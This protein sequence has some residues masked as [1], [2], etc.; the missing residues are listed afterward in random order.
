MEPWPARTTFTHQQGSAAG[1]PLNNQLPL[2]P[3]A[4]PVCSV[5]IVYVGSDETGANGNVRSC[6]CA[7]AYKRK[8][9]GSA[10]SPGMVQAF[11]SDAPAPCLLLYAVAA[12]CGELEPWAA[13]IVRHT[14]LPALH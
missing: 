6:A 10:I 9:V 12:S 14:P 7:C 4:L 2:L 13:T 1:R 5:T 11:A 8:H 3:T